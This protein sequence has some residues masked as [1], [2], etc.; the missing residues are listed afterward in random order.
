[1]RSISVLAFFLT[2]TLFITGCRNEKL[3]DSLDSESVK[4][5][6][7]AN[8]VVGNIQYIKDP[9][10]G[11]CFAYYWGGMA[12]GGPALTTVPEELIPPGLLTVAN[13]PE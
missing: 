13:V 3:P 8:L 9:R 1:M 4:R 2:I 7:T 12:N 5:Q 6:K 11:I 10:T